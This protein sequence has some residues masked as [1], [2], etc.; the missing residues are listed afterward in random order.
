MQRRQGGFVQ[1]NLKITIVAW[2]I[3]AFVFFRFCFPVILGNSIHLLRLI[4]V[5]VVVVTNV[6]VVVVRITGAVFAFFVVI[7]VVVP[8]HDCVGILHGPRKTR[9][10]ERG[11]CCHL[12]YEY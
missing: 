1:Y 8:T 9:G 2:T 3:W 12:E 4:L 6:V 10:S 5:V 7:V 11:W